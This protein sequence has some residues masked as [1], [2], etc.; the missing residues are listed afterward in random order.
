MYGLRIVS[1]VWTPIRVFV[2]TIALALAGI[3]VCAELALHTQSMAFAASF[4]ATHV[5]YASLEDEN[6]AVIRR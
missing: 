4:V 2:A 6:D 5:Y 1:S 3:L